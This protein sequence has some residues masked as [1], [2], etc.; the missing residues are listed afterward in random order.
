MR[1]LFCTNSCY[2]KRKSLILLFIFIFIFSSLSGEIIESWDLD[3][4]FEIEEE[5]TPED[6]LIFDVDHTLILE[7]DLVLR[8]CRRNCLDKLLEMHGET[9][10][11]RRQK[12]I[13]IIILQKEVELI[14]PN[15]ALFIKAL[16]QKEIKAMALT[17][18]KTGPIGL[19]DRVEKCRIAELAALGIDFRTS[20]PNVAT[21]YF[22]F[23][24]HPYSPPLF[25]QGVLFS[26]YYSKG[27]VLWAFLETIQFKPR[28]VIMIDNSYAYLKS[29]ENTLVKM[30]IPFLGI[31]YKQWLQLPF[32]CNEEIARFQV[33]YLI[34]HER[35][36]SDQEAQRLML[37]LIK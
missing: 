3:P 14:D 30:D 31:H 33:R 12:L 22:D 7:K 2:R 4:L 16:Q 13:S 19:I 36:L 35:W 28:Q 24:P 26:S 15:S 5:L 10:P 6:L 34:Q 8:P 17:A 11:V 37:Q 27:Q 1:I 20:F 18:M 29:V 23:L 21:L 25:Y 32:K 9:D